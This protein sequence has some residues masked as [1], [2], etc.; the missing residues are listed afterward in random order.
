MKHLLVTTAA[1]LM[2]GTVAAN[3]AGPFGSN[4][5][6]DGFYVGGDIGGAVSGTDAGDATKT[7][8]SSGFATTPGKYYGNGVTGSLFGGYGLTY[9]SFYFGAEANG[10]LSNLK[11]S[12]GDADLSR[13]YGFGIA[14]RAG[15]LVAPNTLGYGVV[16]WERGRFELNTAS[17]NDKA[18]LDGLRLGAGVEHKLT[19]NISLRGEFDYISWQKKDGVSADEFAL[20]AGVAYR[21]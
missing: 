5:A 19:Q 16:G 7:I 3:A 6:F 10:S 14:G 11:T 1:V 9:N 17:S 2:L 20:K 12:I 8:N 13:K 18:W 21:F 4:S 15:Y